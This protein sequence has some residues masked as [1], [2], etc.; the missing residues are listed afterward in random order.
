M[1][2]V[3]ARVRGGRLVLDEPTSLPDGTEID[4]IVADEADD[5]DDE[6]RA[7]LRA[8]IDRGLDDVRSG[9][10]RPAAEILAELRTRG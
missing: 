7:L 8:A 5:L 6:E 1:A 9:R 3:R 2:A 10:V 4:L